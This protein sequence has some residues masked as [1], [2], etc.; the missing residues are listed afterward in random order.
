MNSKVFN[1]LLKLLFHSII[2]LFLYH[3]FK[4]GLILS[5]DRSNEIYHYYQFDNSNG[6]LK[7]LYIN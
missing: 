6:N 2:N 5:V 1:D 4:I 7:L 3:S